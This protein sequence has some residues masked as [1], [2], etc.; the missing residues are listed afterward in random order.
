MFLPYLQ[1][2]YKNNGAFGFPLKIV[3]NHF[4]V[5]ILPMDTILQFHHFRFPKLFLRNHNTSAS[6][7]LSLHHF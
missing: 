7:R 2:P 1:I 6:D 4:E 3:L 5:M